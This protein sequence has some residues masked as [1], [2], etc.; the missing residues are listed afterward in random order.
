MRYVLLRVRADGFAVG[1]QDNFDKAFGRTKDDRRPVGGGS[2]HP[3]NGNDG[4]HRDSRE[5]EKKNRNTDGVPVSYGVE[6]PHRQGLEHRG[7]AKAPWRVATGIVKR[8]K[9]GGFTGSLD[10]VPGR[11]YSSIPIPTCA[12]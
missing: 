11:P 2:G 1:V 6:E 12:E 5:R 7:R 9:A 8:K 10:G 4:A 3:T